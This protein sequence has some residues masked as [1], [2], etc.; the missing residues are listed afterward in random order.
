MAHGENARIG[1]L[2][3]SAE[4]FADS[5]RLHRPALLRFLTGRL[6]CRSTAE[7]LAQE[8]YLRFF[9]STD[10]IRSPKALLFQ[11][12]GNLAVDHARVQNRRAEILREAHDILWVETDEI[13]PERDTSARQE[14]ARITAAIETLA[15]I[16][17]RIF[18]LTYY[19][20][21]SQQEAA[22]ALGVSRTTVKKH[23][24]RVMDCLAGVAAAASH[25]E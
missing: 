23:M 12:A 16:A 4:A 21:L 14:M 8:A 5:F 22:R 11:I 18:H 3:A 9:G 1:E 6:G 7:D 24:R 10:P 20:G 13:T 15:P 25:G 17:R 19:E 2:A